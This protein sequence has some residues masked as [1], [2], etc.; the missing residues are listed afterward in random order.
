MWTQGQGKYGSHWLP[1]LD[2]IND[3]LIF[4]LTYLAP[5]N[6]EVIANGKLSK[7]RSKL[8]YTS[9]TYDMNKP[10]SS[11]LVA[12]AMGDFKGTTTN[13]ENGTEIGFHPTLV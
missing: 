8:N 7:T 12:F 5:K 11:Y 9:W 2:D 1:S 13:S 3:K 6:Y 4:N 10:M